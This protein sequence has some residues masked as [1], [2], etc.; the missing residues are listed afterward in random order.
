MKYSKEWLSEKEIKK[1]F[2]SP[3]ISSRNIL[4]IK[5][6]YYGAL[7]ISETLN[8]KPEDYRNEDNYYFLVLRKQK[9]DKLN[10]EKQPI[11]PIIFGDLKRYC[12]DNNI[13]SQN[14][15]FSTQK[16]SKMSYN[17]AY[18]II[19][20]LCVDIGINKKITTHSL[21]RSRATHW[22][23]KGLDLYDV[24]KLLRHKSIITTMKYLK[25]SK[26]RLFDKMQEID[27]KLIRIQDV[28]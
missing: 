17:R 3:D 19:K 6:T 9:T 22:L 21:R 10:W 5:I 16:S 27:K 24:S 15:I 2:E 26:K 7:R 13:L 1:I 14:F 12:D 8:S 23:D 4:L 18:T 28:I 11:P 20:E 25:I